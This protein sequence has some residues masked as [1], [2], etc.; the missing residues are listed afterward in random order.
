MWRDDASVNLLSW[1]LT[2][3]P[4]RLELPGPS[5]EETMT[6]TAWA[7]ARLTEARTRADAE[8]ADVTVSGRTVLRVD[9]S[10]RRGPSHSRGTATN[11][12][13]PL[14]K[15]VTS[16]TLG[17]KQ[18]SKSHGPKAERR[19]QVPG[20]ESSGSA[21]PVQS[22]LFSNSSLHPQLARVPMSE[23]FPH[24]QPSVAADVITRTSVPP[25][26]SH[27]RATDVFTIGSMSPV[28]RIVSLTLWARRGA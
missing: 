2:I 24:T 17:S 9:Q 19:F 1:W 14:A 13:S 4:P 22:P 3:A 20:A 21:T 5:P 28:A 7:V 6:S 26:V 27:R 15:V 16:Q 23:A 25:S 10:S 12:G 8:S 18:H 11:E